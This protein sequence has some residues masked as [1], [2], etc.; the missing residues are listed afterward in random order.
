MTAGH[1]ARDKKLEEL[2]RPNDINVCIDRLCEH[3][4][5]RH[6]SYH[7]EITEY[8]AQKMPF[9]VTNYSEKWVGRYLLQRYALVDPPTLA[10]FNQERVC[11]WS[12]LDWSSPM[13][14]RFKAD[15]KAHGIG[16][17]GLMVSQ[18]DAQ[19]RRFHVNFSNDLNPVDWVKRMQEIQPQLITC[20][21]L[22]H[23]K[24]ILLF[25]KNQDEQPRLTPRE[26]ECLR[27]SA[28]GKEASE[29]ARELT[30]S[31]HTVRDYL[32]SARWKLGAAN[33]AQAVHRATVLRM[34]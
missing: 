27:F 5:M 24:I 2:L 4:E 32:K 34:I 18:S 29:V 20:A 31:E 11:Y 6:A 8:T 7:A 30:L 33:I 25:L 21:R 9:V 17:S 16:Q 14:Q 28:K 26:L 23:E 3:F 1:K 15:A 12:D 19:R 22:L 13:S 10:G